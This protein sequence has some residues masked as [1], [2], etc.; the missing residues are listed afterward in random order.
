MSINI[1]ARTLRIIQDIGLTELETKAYIALLGMGRGSADSVARRADIKRASAYVALDS[2]LQQ[3]LVLK[4]PRARKMI[5]IAK[6]PEDLAKLV[7]DKLSA[8]QEIIPELRSLAVGSKQFNIV[9][10]EGIR[11]I[12]KALWYKIDDMKNIGYRAFF[13]TAENISEELDSLFVRWNKVN[14]RQNIR[15]KAIAPIHS[16]LADYRSSDVE[17]LREVKTIPYSLYPNQNSI[18]IYDNFIRIVMFEEVS[19]VII[20]SPTLAKSFAAVHEM[21]WQTID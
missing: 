16:S 20:E 3:G 9:L 13:G 4:V 15:A 1:S 19:A 18:E 11:G 21:L 14:A 7:G 5:F 8:I 2:L 12:E 10:Y 6:D 17:N